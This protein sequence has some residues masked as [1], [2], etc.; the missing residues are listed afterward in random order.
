[1]EDR[2]FEGVGFHPWIGDRYGAD[3]RFGVRLLVLGESH[4]G[5][6]RQENPMETT[7]VVEWYTQRARTGKGERYRFFTV[8]ANILRGQAG[9]IDD[10]DLADIF[11]E[12]AF[13]NFVQTFV[14]DGPRGD[15]TFRQWVDAQAPL[16]TVLDALRPDAVLVLGRELW[17]HILEPPAGPAFEVVAHPSSSHLRYA[18]AM[19]AFGDLVERAKGRIAGLPDPRP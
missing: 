8:I 18:E 12:I 1:M 4:Y 2:R 9:W 5:A 3:S 6:A 16:K 17:G 7:K 13:Y 19:P 11:Q 14:G 10:D 15:P